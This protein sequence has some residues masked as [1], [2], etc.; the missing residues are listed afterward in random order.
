MLFIINRL[1][2]A[3]KRIEREIKDLKM[4]PPLNCWAAP[5]NDDDM[6]RWQGVI[7]GPVPM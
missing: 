3:I 1:Y 2:M 4:N 5:I 6:F 7:L